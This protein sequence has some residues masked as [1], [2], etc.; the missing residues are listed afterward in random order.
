MFRNLPVIAATPPGPPRAT[1]VI[2]MLGSP[3]PSGGTVR[4]GAREGAH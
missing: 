1:G 2:A 4:W 3:R